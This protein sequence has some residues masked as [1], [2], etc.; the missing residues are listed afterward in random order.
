LGIGALA[1]IAGQYVVSLSK[2]LKAAVLV[3][4]ISIIFLVTLSLAG[5]L[6]FVTRSVL[7]RLGGGTLVLGWTAVFLLGYAVRSPRR[8]VSKGF[9][10]TLIAIVAVVF[11]IEGSGRLWWR[12]VAVNAW[13]HTP[14]TAGGLAQSSG[15]TCS[16]AAAVMLLHHHGIRSSEG[17]I[18]Y[19]ANTTL[20]GTDGFD[21]ARALSEKVRD[22]GWRANIQ[23]TDYGRCLTRNTPF[24]AHVAD[25]KVG[26]HAVFIAALRE[27]HAEMI[28]PLVGCKTK[29]SRRHFENVWDGTAIWIDEK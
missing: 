13:E 4:T 7:S 21:L 12:F 5:M 26:A 25:P 29:V 14:D 8:T 24:V 28:D 6:P 15:W 11:V 27:D 19:L 1:F 9:L 2:P 10:I 17:E 23:E 18:A 3:V 22:R 20:F 16:P